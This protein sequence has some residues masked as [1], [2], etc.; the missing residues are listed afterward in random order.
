VSDPV[1]TTPAPRDSDAHLADQIEA[2]F[3]AKRKELGVAD[4]L[5]D[6]PGVTTLMLVAFGERGIK[7]STIWRVVLPM[8]SVAGLRTRLER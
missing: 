4:E 7:T 6:I 8:I 5:R 2:S 3:D 1:E